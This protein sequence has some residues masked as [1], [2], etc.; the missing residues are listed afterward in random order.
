V[1]TIGAERLTKCPRKAKNSPLQALFSLRPLRATGATLVLAHDLGE[2]A[3]GRCETPRSH[4]VAATA[5][6]I[7]PHL[8]ASGP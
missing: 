2:D 6:Q 1:L 8:S 3:D 7:S 5:T 4:A